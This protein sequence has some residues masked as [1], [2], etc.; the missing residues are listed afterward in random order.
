M[1]RAV[2]RRRKRKKNKLSKKKSKNLGC[3]DCKETDLKRL[4]YKIYEEE[5]RNA[6]EN[7]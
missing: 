3:E 4:A 5:C 6:L 2:L 1:K 7:Y